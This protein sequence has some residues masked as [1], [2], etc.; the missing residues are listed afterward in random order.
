MSNEN[1]QSV[2]DQ[3]KMSSFF[4]VAALSPN[5]LISLICAFLYLIT[6]FPELKEPVSNVIASLL[7]KVGVKPS[8]SMTEDQ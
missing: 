7:L 2:T 6:A 8:T 5:F 3:V 1:N 4:V